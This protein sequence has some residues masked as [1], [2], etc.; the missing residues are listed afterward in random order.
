MPN[1][2]NL[3]PAKKGEIRNPKGKAKG[4]RNRSTIVKEIIEAIMKDEG[5]PVVD[6]MTDAV[7]RKAMLGDVTAW[8]KLMDSAYGKVTDKQEITGAN[9]G[10]I[11]TETTLQDSDRDIIT[12]YLSQKEGVNVSKD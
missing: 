12:R 4:T 3:I 2:E 9:G 10:A 7:V 1:P 5:K 6:L 11:K 8:D